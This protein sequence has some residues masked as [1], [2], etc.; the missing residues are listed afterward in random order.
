MAFNAATTTAFFTNAPQMGLTNEARIRLAVEGLATVDDFADFD[1]K[2][3]E[4]AVDNLRTYI[5]PIPAIPEVLDANN[6]VIQAAVPAVPGLRP[7]IITARQLTRLKVAAIAYAYYADIG[8]TLTP[9]NMN[10]TNVLRNFYIE[11]EALIKLTKEDSPDVPILSKNLTPIKWI[12]SFKDYLGRSFGVRNAPLSHV[13]R[14]DENVPAEATDPL[15]AGSAFGESG[16]VIDE[17]VNRLDHAH[18]LFKTDNASVY[19]KLDEAT[20]G[21]IF[22]ATIKPHANRKN[23]RAAWLSLISSHAGEDKWEKEHKVKL[24]FLMNQTWNGKSYSLEKF[25]GIHRNNFIFLQEAVNHV[26][27]QLPTEHSRVGY[28]LD[29]ITNQDPDLRAALA[30]IRAN[31]NNMRDDFEAAVAFLL[32]VCPYA[33]SRSDGKKKSVQISDTRL[34]NQ[35]DSETGVDFRWYKPE[36]FGRLKKNQKKELIK[37]QNSKVGKAAVLKQ[38]KDEG[39]DPADVPGYRGAGSSGGSGKGKRG[40]RKGMRATINSLEQQLAAKIKALEAKS[41]KEADRTQLAEI[42]ELLVEVRGDKKSSVGAVSAAKRKE[43]DTSI[44]VHA[45]KLQSILKRKKSDDDKE[46]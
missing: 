39:V 32:P 10:Y 42:K 1:A 7:C 24:A 37:W 13:I 2:S 22:G 30:S 28:L 34:K 21:T 16:S 8:R 18:P 23:G 11:Y 9:A 3:L 17:L 15:V 43:P 26:T 45:L 41:A 14:E 40:S 46:E 12:E 4:T 5:R 31:N 33:K 27:F 38:F 6:N 20:R 36:E 19:S 44:E 35:S 29:N 25:C